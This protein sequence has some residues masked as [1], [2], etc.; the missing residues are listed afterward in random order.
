MSDE[1]VNVPVLRND[2]KTL[3]ERMS[4][5]AYQNILPARYLK[6]NEDGDVIESQ[7]EFFGRVANNIAVAEAIFEDGVPEGVA[8]DFTA[9]DVLEG[10][11]FTEEGYEA[12]AEWAGKFEDYMENLKFIPNTPTLI[13]AGTEMQQLSACFVNS[14]EDDIQDIGETETEAKLIFQ[15]GGGVG[16]D[17]GKLRPY[18]DIV[19]STGG[20]ASG[21]I[22]FMQDYDQSC[23]TIAQGGVRRGAQM[24]TMPV[25]HPD[26]IHFI[27]AKNRDVSLAH[28]LKLNDPDDPTYTDFGSAIEE[29]RE[30]IDG[31]GR[32]PKHLR[33]AV[34]GHLSNFNISVTIPD[35]FMKALQNDEEYTLINPR[36][37]EPHI[38][39][40][41]T[42]EMYSWFDLED[43]VTVGE[44]LTLPAEEIWT[45]IVEGAH[46]NG[47]PG[48][49]FIDTV[50]REHS[51]DTEDKPE[52][53]MTTSNPCGEQNLME[54]E[55]CLHG[56][57]TLL[58][59]DGVRK[60]ED[61]KGDKVTSHSGI[62]EISS[63]GKLIPQ[64]KKQTI[65]VKLDGDIPI[66]CT[67]D[68]EFKTDEGW[69]EAQNLIE[70]DASVKWMNNNPLTSPVDMSAEG[71]WRAFSIGWMH[72]DGWLTENSLGISFNK[73]DGD[74]EIKEEVLDHY[75]DMFGSRKPL[76]D[77]DTSYQEQT[78][79]MYAYE[80][81]NEFG[82][83]YARATERSFPGW[84]YTASENEQLAF[85]RG[86]FTA[87]AGIGG[88]NDQQVQY[89]T[90]SYKLADELQKTLGSFGI[91]TRRYV[92]EF[93]DR[94]DQLRISITKESAKE[95]ME[96]IGIQTSEKR[97]RFN[98][99]GDNYS[100]KEYLDVVSI[101]DNEA[102]QVYDLNVPETNQFFTNGALVHNCNLGHINLSTIVDEDVTP[103]VEYSKAGGP[104]REE[105]VRGFL[106]QAIDWDE[107][108]HR[109]EV[110]TRFL[111]NVVTM[112]DFPIPEIEE[113]V[114]K[115]R[116]IGL[117]IMGLAQ[118]YVQLG[119]EYGSEAG[120]EIA[121]QLMRHI[122]HE[123]KRVS[124]QLALVRGNFEN[125]EDSKYSD[126]DE[127]SEWIED[128]CGEELALLEDYVEMR[129]H[130]T[131]TIA[132]TGTTSM[133]GNTTGGCEPIYNVA[134]YKN[135]TDD[136]QG[137]EMLVEFDSLFLKT[138]EAN[139]IDVD[140]VKEEA[141]ELMANNEF[142]GVD[143]LT[144]VPREVADLFVTTGDLDSQEHASVMCALQEGVDSSISKTLNAPYEAT[145]EDAKDTFEYVYEN[146]GKSVTFYRDGSRTKQVKTTRQDN[147]DVDG[148]DGNE[149]GLEEHEIPFHREAPDVLDNLERHRIQTGKGKLYVSIGEDE[150]GIV[151][152][153]AT[154]GKSGGTMES[155]TEA[156]ARQISQSFQW[157]VPADQ[158]IEQLENIKSPDVAWDGEDTVHSIPDGI[159]LALKRYIGKD[160]ENMI[161][162]T[163]VDVSDQI[164]EQHQTSASECKQ[165]GAMAV[166]QEEGCKTC[167]PE[168]G[169][170]SWSKCS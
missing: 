64:G 102:A 14:P 1:A 53:T 151:E 139:N 7:E 143:D 129:N 22:T 68:H 92:T 116:K 124:S 77:D 152:V 165:C 90:S 35:E 72:G 24:G 56:N 164:E 33:N 141:Q 15:S 144:T 34:E 136:I 28:T 84:F 27:H 45:R 6:K 134:F 162:H 103:W 121:R 75:H 81:A 142:D 99:D 19:G 51:F 166:V 112:S 58:T 41:E 16:Y 63:G 169:G 157:G 88:K 60:I 153:M 50:N 91:Q 66:R 8:P 120:N 156:L 123:S 110:G 106:E 10:E 54:Y 135:V 89:A 69:V 146:D 133:I 61:F 159:A 150:H 73:E 71:A 9:E 118:L 170:C 40:E 140:E 154:V 2:E 38:A 59:D 98:F 5:N 18:G 32:V 111:D 122:N 26:I 44:E 95:F 137:D 12:W 93:D 31:E 62:S 57:E 145:V 23:E 4:E 114:R 128:H 13:N 43:E 155:F 101:E 79:A 132:P 17:F 86:L 67:L 160:E 105:T 52:Y 100:D 108:N 39:T 37:D 131:T 78:E 97:H 83:N 94:E 29:A 109:I 76:K 80:K 126:A 36:T 130:N 161:D 117:G 49:M 85:L 115:N 119:V 47:E 138:L 158:V 127:Y 147:E 42:K 149:K 148:S 163:T 30:M 25:T 125:W 21:P 20:I 113:T 11:E 48:V 107:F 70:E 65:T 3:E 168:L 55:A 104:S 82:F 87:D 46:Q 167:K 74:F 96:Y